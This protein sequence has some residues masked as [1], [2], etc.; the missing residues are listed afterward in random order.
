MNE[1]FG[2]LGRNNTDKGK[3]TYLGRSLS[4]AILYITNPTWITDL[5]SNLD[6]CC[7]RQ[8]IFIISLFNDLIPMFMNSVTS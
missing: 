1:T 4:I 6:F 8:A 7:E 5:E 2:A 3:P